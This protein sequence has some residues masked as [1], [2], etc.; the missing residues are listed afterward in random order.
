MSLLRLGRRGFSGPLRRMADESKGAMTRRLEELEQEAAGEQTSVFSR[1]ELAKLEQR[2]AQADLSVKVQAAVSEEQHGKPWLGEESTEDA[3]RRMLEDSRKPAKMPARLPV[4]I[5]PPVK[6]K[7]STV[8]DRLVAARQEA[9]KYSGQPAEER[10]AFQKD[11]R[12][13]FEPSARA[14]PHTLRGLISLADERIMDAKS[15]GQFDSVKKLRGKA[16]QR[17][18]LI[19]SPF[20]DTTEHIL[21]NMVKRQEIVPP[22]IDRQ[23]QIQSALNAFRLRLRQAWRHHC[24][25]QIAQTGLALD[26]QL[27]KARG[28]AAAELSGSGDLLRDA[29]WEK[30]EFKYHTAAMK[31][32]N[33]QVRNYNL[34][35]PATA[36]KGL[37]ILEKEL[38]SC[39]KDVAA[40][41]ATAIHTKAMLPTQPLTVD[42]SS[43]FDGLFTKLERPLERKENFYGFRQFW[44]D[45]KRSFARS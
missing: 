24:M 4:T 28:F 1:E 39:F 45:L 30:I 33:Y 19:H 11:L 26:A 18:H 43:I 12:S 21:N 42:S 40:D 32:V 7:K 25:R 13:R 34:I 5:R 44:S 20:I 31:D 38:N 2:I 3:A 37:Y 9:V 15:R 6:K 36:R 17:D 41:L 16:L 22:W 23:Q 29:E 35:A 10:E 14:M 27:S 8:S